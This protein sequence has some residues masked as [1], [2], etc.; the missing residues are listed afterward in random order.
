L[1]KRC[2]GGGWWKSLADVTV[3]M[4]LLETVLFADKVTASDALPGVSGRGD[5]RDERRW[6]RS[7]VGRMRARVRGAYSE[8]AWRSGLLRTGSSREIYAQ[9][10][11]YLW[12]GCKLDVAAA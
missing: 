8:S 11:R 9:G 1:E 6:E 3:L 10:L 5:W 7:F 12:I 2:V 4:L